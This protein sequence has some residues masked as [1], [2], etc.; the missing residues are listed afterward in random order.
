MTTGPAHWELALR[1]RAMDGQFFVA[2]CSP[3]R[4]EGASYVAWGHS[5]AVGPFAEVLA[6]AG[7]G[8]E[9]VYADMDFAQV[10]D[11]DVT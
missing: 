8:A 9:I 6:A 4:V 3:A 1:A 10:G 7:S 5:T 11:G 2:G